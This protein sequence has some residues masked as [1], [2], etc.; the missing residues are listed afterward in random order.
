MIERMTAKYP[1][2][3]AMMRSLEKY[4]TWDS[5]DM[6]FGRSMS[7]WLEDE[8][9]ELMI[10]LIVEFDQ[11]I[12]IFWIGNWGDQ[13]KNKSMCH[14]GIFCAMSSYSNMKR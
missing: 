8:I 6:D 13:I 3:N 12:N 7:E 14:L 1:S 5:E 11:Q 4:A 2:E 10:E 9:F